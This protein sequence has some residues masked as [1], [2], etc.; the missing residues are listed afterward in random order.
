MADAV[1]GTLPPPGDDQTVPVPLH[2]LSEVTEPRPHPEAIRDVRES[3]W[4][5]GEVGRFAERFEQHLIA[6]TARA[7]SALAACFPPGQEHCV[8]TLLRAVE[9]LAAVHEP[10]AAWQAESELHALGDLLRRHGM[11]AEDCHYVGH[12]LMRAA[13]DCYTG[14]WSTHLGSAWTAVHSWL[15]LHLER[16]V[17]APVGRAGAPEL[18]FPVIRIGADP[19][20]APD[21][22][23][24]APDDTAALRPSPRFEDASAGGWARPSAAV[25]AGAG[26]RRQAASP[27]RSAPV[28]PG[29]TGWFGVDAPASGVRVGP[30]GFP[31][32]PTPPAALAAGAI[33][34]PPDQGGVARPAG[35]TSAGSD[36]GTA[37][38]PGPAHGGA[39]RAG[40]A[41]T[42]ALRAGGPQAGALQA[43]ALQVGPVQS[44]RSEAA[45]LAEALVPTS[46][47]S[48]AEIARGA[49]AVPAVTGGIAI[50]GAAAGERRLHPGMNP[51]LLPGLPPGLHASRRRFGRRTPP[52]LRAE[53]GRLRPEPD[54]G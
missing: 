20:S 22:T 18:G 4:Q 45:L 30:D 15:V 51:G 28:V 26:T 46:G 17:P 42:D 2:A 24:P 8:S 31:A 37:V 29:P 36:E 12:A 53:P 14:V 39:P 19:P 34:K 43:G 47:L 3:C 13:R 25:V 6:L 23:A 54:Q 48:K 40:S 11:S 33:S 35:P 38:P 1:A 9:A 41:H 50:A 7:E 10:V 32:W 5:L 52:P 44:R 21:E 49:A 16:A 27:G